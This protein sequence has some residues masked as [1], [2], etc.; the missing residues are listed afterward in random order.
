MA[1]S[2][3]KLA[4][5]SRLLDEAL[6]LDDAARRAWLAG[7]PDDARD[8]EPA[9]REALLRA[10]DAPDDSP[11]DTPPRLAAG[12]DAPDDAPRHEPGGRIGPYELIRPL[13]SGGMADVWLARRADGAFRRDVALKLPRDVARRPDLVERFARE[14]DLLASLEH[15]HIARF[16]DAGSDPVAGPYLAMEYVRGQ[17]ITDWCDEH[18]RTLRE[19]LAL[20]LQVLDAVRAAHSRGILHRDLKPS[21]VLVTDDGEARLLDFGI[22]GLLGAGTQE[23]GELTGLYGR[24]LTP[25]YASP[26]QLAGGRA[27]AQS[28]LYALGV[29]LHELLCGARPYALGRQR[30]LAEFERA[31]AA[32]EPA[33]PSARVAAGAGAR[34]GLDDAGLARALRGELDRIVQKALARSPEARYRRVEELAADLGQYLSPGTVAAPA[35]GTSTRLALGLAALAV[36]V[37]GGWLLARGGGLAPV[38]P[39]VGTRSAGTAPVSDA[40]IAVLPF[41]DM[42]ERQDQGYFSDSLSEELIDMLA[43]IRG[44]EVIARTSSFYFRNRPATVPEIAAALH[45]ATVL[46]GSVRK[47]GDSI[48]VTAQLIRADTGVHLWSQTYDRGVTDV[49]KVQDDIAAAVVSALKVRLLPSQQIDNPYRSAVPEAYAQYLKGR[50][51]GLRGTLEDYRAALD[52]YRR[53]VALDPGYVVA[54]VGV[55]LAETHVAVYTND[56]AGFARAAAAAERALAL[57]PQQPYGYQARA[58]LRMNTLDMAGARDD[59]ARAVALSPG[60]SKLQNTYGATLACLGLLDE[61]IGTMRRAIELDPLNSDAWMNLGYY[62]TATRDYRGARQALSRALTLNPSADNIHLLMAQLEL[63]EG[64]ADAAAAEFAKDGDEADRAMGEA[65]VADAKGDRAAPIARSRR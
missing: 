46:E 9:L 35:R 48:R 25:D 44:L 27:D 5:L 13:G 8:L 21:N 41:V 12:P 17:P 10:D 65:L 39:G 56:Q 58:Y 4:Q 20:F 23:V 53:A 49:F 30:S 38:A 42:S 37:V 61:A 31:L 24:A 22:G 59:A 57:A 7:L 64:R 18:R 36:V 34:R 45:V 62:Q 1:L 6:P 33:A 60:E 54:A 29:L 19:R 2:V 15:A 55:S 40:S 32:T 52:A 51:A 26:E 28:D 16:Y 63:V 43:Q 47:S 14:R 11:L 50:Q 3:A